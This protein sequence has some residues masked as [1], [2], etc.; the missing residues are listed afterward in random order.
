MIAETAVPPPGEQTTTPGPA[1]NVD[2]IREILF[3]SHMREYTQRF[4]RIEERLAGETAELKAE[5]C[6]RL[7]SL[8][9]HRR[10]EMDALT[11]RLNTERWER[12]ESAERFARELN[13]TRE[14]LNQRL[15]QAGEEMAKDVRDLRQLA[16]DRH[17]SLSDELK[18]YVNTA[19]ALQG[20]RLEELRSSSL[21][22]FALADLLAELALRIRGEFPISGDGT[23]TDASIDG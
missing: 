18:Q 2:R 20:R 7:E 11:D 10:Q 13:D 12:C 3:G 22:R 15:R 19:D 23:A 5:I 16:L 17:R 6:R 8:D 1:D 21:N 14:S 9:A 4:L